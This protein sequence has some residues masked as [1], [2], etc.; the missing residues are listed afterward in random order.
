MAHHCHARGCKVEV[1]PQMLMCSR[2]W[3]MVPRHIRRRVWHHYREGQCDDKRPSQAWLEAADDAI[4]AVWERENS[5]RGSRHLFRTQAHCV[6]GA[7]TEADLSNPDINR[8]RFEIR[9]PRGRVGA[10]ESDTIAGEIH[11]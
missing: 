5:C 1:P 10:S 7:F 2:H 4:A 9:I 8:V 6:C 3:Y 11:T